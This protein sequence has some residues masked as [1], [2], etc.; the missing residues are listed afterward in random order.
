VYDESNWRR[1]FINSNIG[2][3]HCLPS[4]N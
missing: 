1:R 2:Y 4:M 3:L